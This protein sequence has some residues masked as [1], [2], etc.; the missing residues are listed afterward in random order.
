MKTILFLVGSL[1]AESIN[2]RVSRIAEQMLPDGYRAV[3]FELADV[4]VFNADHVAADTPDAVRG[5]REAITNADGVFWA[6]PEFNYAIPGV[7]KNAIDWASRPM[8]PRNSMV[9]KPMNAVVA[10]GSV[11]NGIRGLTDLKRTWN[12]CG[13]AAVGFDFVLQQAP[14]KFIETRGVDDL[15]PA[16]RA[17]LQFNVDNLV[18]AVE[19]DFGAVPLA[20]WE[21]YVRTLS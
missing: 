7:V 5:L 21:A 6:T 1:R 18:R 8:L 12:N 16:T 20:N 4:P 9:G 17:T 13:G 2:R 3:R 15:K 11:N 14:Q 19:G 10:T